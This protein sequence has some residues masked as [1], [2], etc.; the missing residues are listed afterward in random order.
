[1]LLGR[2]VTGARAADPQSPEFR[3]MLDA[4]LAQLGTVTGNDDQSW[5]V[6][7]APPGYV[8]V[9]INGGEIY[10]SSE[11]MEHAT[12]TSPT[13]CKPTRST[14]SGG[15]CQ[16]ACRATNTHHIPHLFATAGSGGTTHWPH[17]PV[18][19]LHRRPWCAARTGTSPTLSLRPVSQHGRGTASEHGAPAAPRDPRRF[20]RRELPRGRSDPAARWPGADHR[21]TDTPDD[22]RYLPRR[23]RHC[24]RPDLTRA[25]PEHPTRIANLCRAQFGGR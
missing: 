6:I 5:C 20:G 14:S 22:R 2:A 13:N 16:H 8:G 19:G 18:T 24:Q 15:P 12:S 25:V 3:A 11:S 9:G 21:P 1:M 7:P 10:A 17:A 23:R 4:I